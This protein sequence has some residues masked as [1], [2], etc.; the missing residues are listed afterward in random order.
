MPDGPRELPYPVTAG[1]PRE[2]RWFLRLP[3]WARVPGMR[4]WMMGS[5]HRAKAAMGTVMVTAIR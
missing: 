4:A 5:P 3:Q 1:D 2:L